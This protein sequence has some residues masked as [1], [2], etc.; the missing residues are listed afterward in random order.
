MRQFFS[1]IIL[2]IGVSLNG[3]GQKSAWK[4]IMMIDTTSA[5]G[6]AVDKVASTKYGP[7]NLFDNNLKTCWVTGTS[8][9]YMLVPQY[10]RVL[11]LFNGYGKSL[12]L[13]L[14]NDRPKKLRISFYLG[15]QPDGHA[16]L[17]AAEYY[18]YDPH[19]N[20]I[21]DLDD[22]MGIQHI[23][24]LDSMFEDQ[25]ISIDAFNT[26]AHD[27][28]FEINEVNPVIKIEVIDTYPGT[29]YRD[30]CI[31]E[32]YFSD[33]YMVY[34]AGNQSNTIDTLYINEDDNEL[35]AK[36]NNGEAQVLYKN[37]DEDVW[38]S[39][40]S[41]NQEW[42]IIMT[43]PAENRGRGLSKFLLINTKSKTVVNDDL[44]LS[45]GIPIG[46]IYLEYQED[47]LFLKCMDVKIQQEVSIKLL[48]E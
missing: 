26:F 23:A 46:E 45:L 20:Q 38:L 44:Q 41:L 47:E 36:Y 11:N 1:L 19:I 2:T 9:I 48:Q 22:V 40:V 12:A 17:M 21:V 10:N 31:S 4:S 29:K 15:V 34:T 28:G 39:E 35:I 3:F 43:M 16:S 18:L 14:Q 42:V 33:K 27:I 25:L 13:Y 37:K 30:V 32:L 24:M 5:Y 7:N 6:F 8:D